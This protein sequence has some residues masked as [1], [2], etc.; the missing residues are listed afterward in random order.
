[1]AA[2]AKKILL[3]LFI[4]LLFFYG[5]YRFDKQYNENAQQPGIYD[6]EQPFEPLR[7]N[8]GVHFHWFI[9]D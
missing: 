3:S 6:A 1:M 7:R 9:V 4:S 5:F 2:R 8:G